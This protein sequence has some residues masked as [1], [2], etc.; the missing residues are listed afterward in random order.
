MN[1]NNSPVEIKVVLV[2]KPTGT[3]KT[4][5]AINMMRT[6]TLKSVAAEYHAKL[7][8]GNIND[9]VVLTKDQHDV[10][11]KVYEMIGDL[12]GLLTPEEALA[13]E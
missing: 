3:I 12:G 1:N 6:R 10:Y 2:H 8:Q 7:P 4:L 9:F 11:C 13:H 5:L